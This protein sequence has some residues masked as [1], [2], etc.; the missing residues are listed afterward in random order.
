MDGKTEGRHAQPVAGVA[1]PGGS[2]YVV[3]T[4]IGNLGD[5]SDRARDT[6]AAV[7]LIA[8][9][10]TRVSRRLLTHFGIDCPLTSL[11]QHS[12]PARL[13]ALID[14]L[15]AG[16]SIAFV[17][18]AG[19]P[20][21]SDPGA[22]LVRAAHDRGIR[23]IPIPGPSAITA[24]VSVAG[25]NAARFVFLGFL[26][27]RGQARALLQSVA[28]LPATALVVL[29]APHRVVATLGLLAATLVDGRTL[30]VCREVTKH[31]ETIHRL[32][33]ADAVAW[34]AEDP[35]RQRGEFVLVVDA[36]AETEPATRESIDSDRVLATL[37]SELPVAQA[38]RLA[39][40]LTGADR[41]TTYGRAL[42]LL[43]GIT[44]HARKHGHGEPGDTGEP[45]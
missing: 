25:L 11:H 2:L 18:D 19:T 43:P 5:L 34:I 12:D 37:L 4:P 28:V 7:D 44:R 20:A 15:A 33:L 27:A 24:A 16:E 8:A 23:V 29:E 13:A 26:P 39:A 6:F 21:V 1:R 30:T 38:A 36:A 32:P 45:A 31:F 22:A 42:E 9:E 35:N 17:T 41:A 3:A 14:R 40:R 10:D